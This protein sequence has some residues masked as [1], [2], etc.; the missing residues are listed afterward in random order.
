[1]TTLDTLTNESEAPRPQRD[2]V[3][4]GIHATV[5]A[6]CAISSGYAVY[7]L[8]LQKNQDIFPQVFIGSILGVIGLQYVT[9]RV[10]D[11]VRPYQNQ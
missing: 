8:G 10:L 4:T 2:Y 3:R 5:T 1:M 6:L 11:K 9:S 7:K